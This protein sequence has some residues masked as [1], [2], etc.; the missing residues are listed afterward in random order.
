MIRSP[1]MSAPKAAFLIALLLAAPKASA[2]NQPEF[3]VTRTTQPPK[4]DG[5]LD[6]AAWQAGALTLGD[7]RSYS[8]LRGESG[9][10]D[11]QVFV[12]YDERNLYFAFHCLDSEPDKIRTTLTRRDNAFNDDWV[13]LS[14][15]STGTRQTSYHLMV[16]PSGIQMDAVNTTSS[17]ERF[18][19][20]LVWDSAGKITSDGYVVEIAIP[21]QTIRF[22]NGDDIRMG[23]LF[24]RH[25][26]RTGKS[27]SWPDMPPGDWVFER[28]AHLVFDHLTQR[29][30]VEVIPSATLPVSETRATP[31]RWNPVTGKADAGLSGKFGITS[32]VT[33][34]G[35]VNPDF[36]QVESDAFQV[37]VNQRF[38]VFF[39]EKRPFFMEGLG[40]FNIAGTGGDGNMRI[41]VHTRHIVDPSWGAKVTGT[42]SGFTFGFLSSSDET[43]EDIGDRG[44]GVAGK[45]KLFNI[46]RATYGLGGSNYVGAIATDTEHAGRHNR[47][48]GGDVSFKVHHV[49][50]F[51]ATYLYSQTGVEPAPDTHGSAAQVTYSLSTHRVDA[52]SQLE[53][54]DRDFQMDTAFYNRT[55]FTSGWSYGA[56]YFYPSKDNRFG[57]VKVF[58]FVWSKYGHDRTQGGHERFELTGIRFNFTR[59]GFLDVDYAHGYESWDGQRFRSGHPFGTFGNV[60]VVRWLYVGGNFHYGFGPY[61]DPINPYLGKAINWELNGTWQPNRHFS[62]YLD[63][64]VEHFDRASTGARVFDVRIVNSKSTYQFNKQFLIRLL[65]QFDGSNHRLLTDLLASYEL[66]PG[67]VF[68]AGYGS[69]FEQRAFQNGELVPNSGQYVTVSRGLFF[70]AS[71]LHRF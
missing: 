32:N 51:S 21:L 54:Y 65:E 61:Y 33:L 36:S 60:Q 50:S 6:D 10:P 42:G 62:E 5:D 59:Q 15:D 64:N 2:Q 47:V 40:L 71:Y 66:V 55:G 4:I 23:I 43:P 67:T 7:W 46:A 19:T 14:L 24:W 39:D 9:S 69:N 45:S 17:G 44:D 56:L 27:F 58:P 29:R 12:A 20:D 37:Q 48:A 18:E 31:D 30:L 57:L 68:Y 63:Y 26:S 35:T 16:N 25:V 22:S 70:K 11:T 1:G 13:G 38:P 34:D 52:I 53:N 28:H 41:A 8:P 49:N 3:R